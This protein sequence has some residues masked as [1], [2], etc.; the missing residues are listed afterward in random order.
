VALKIVSADVPEP[1]YD[2]QRRIM[3]MP[4]GLTQTEK[5]HAMVTLLCEKGECGH[6]D[7]GHLTRNVG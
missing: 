2:S 7:D 4:L 6:S 1:V 5:Y 3:V